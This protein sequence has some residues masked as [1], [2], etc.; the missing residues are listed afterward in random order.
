MVKLI[1]PISGRVDIAPATEMEFSSLIPG[2]VK[3]DTIKID[4]RVVFASRSALKRDSVKQPSYVVD[5]RHW[6]PLTWRPKSF[7][8]ISW[9]RQLVE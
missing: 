3:P 1:E 5:R 2:W 9:P 7:F 4:I 6:Q 8:A